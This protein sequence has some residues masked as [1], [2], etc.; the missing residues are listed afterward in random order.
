MVKLINPAGGVT[1]VHESR[2]E[3]YKARGFRQAAP[4]P[5]KK[6]AGRKK[7]GG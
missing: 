6:P 1:W 5:N 3:E 4:Q 2:V 7:T